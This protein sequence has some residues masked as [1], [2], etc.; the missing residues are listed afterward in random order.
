[1]R[2]NAGFLL[3]LA[4]CTFDASGLGE[5]PKTP[6][7]G[8]TETTTAS[9]ETAS[10]PTTGPTTTT[11]SEETVGV[12][13]SESM[14]EGGPGDPTSMPTLTTT[15]EPETTT[16][17]S[18]DT[19]PDI[20]TGCPLVMAYKDFDNDYFG[21]PTMPAM[22]CEGTQG[23]VPDNTDCNDM[24]ANAH[25]GITEMCDGIDNDCDGVLD[26]YDAETNA[27]ECGACRFRVRENS[28]YYFC[29]NAL[30]WEPAEAFCVLHGLHLVKDDGG[31]EHDWLLMEMGNTGGWWTGAN[32]REKENEFKWVSDG[33]NVAG[34][35]WG[36]GEPNDQVWWPSEDGDC[37]MLL[38]SNGE[39]GYPG[40]GGRWNDHV[41]DAGFKFICE[42]PLP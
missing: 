32:D 36:N 8:V 39:L 19:G 33:V 17:P 12:S 24:S 25:P 34:D 6:E 38:D 21:D 9:T 28:L 11:T 13:G 22:V 5:T 31:P 1:M 3:A 14:T 23:W 35:L 15:T 10:P 37:V 26:E 7:P 30:E 29:S 18:T 2:W 16:D 27:T 42:G 41:C 40:S 4:G 20:T